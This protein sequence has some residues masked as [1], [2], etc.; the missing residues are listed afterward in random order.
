[1]LAEFQRIKTFLLELLMNTSF[2]R[3]GYGVAD[4]ELV[5]KEHYYYIDKTC[6]IPELEETG[7]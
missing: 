5:Q 4:F 6:F 7:R 3:I 2:K 1:V